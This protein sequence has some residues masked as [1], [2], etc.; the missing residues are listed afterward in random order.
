MPNMQLFKDHVQTEGVLTVPELPLFKEH[1]QIEV[2]LTVPDM[3]LF[4]DHVQPEG[5]LTVPE[6]HLFK[7]RVQTEGVLTVLDM[8]PFLGGI[9]RSG[10]T[11]RMC[12]QDPVRDRDPPS[13]SGVRMMIVIRILILMQLPDRGSRSGAGS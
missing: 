7:D 6:I 13:G 8:Q 12:I 4:K 1:V 3:Q 11:V 2:V 9:C 5:V 10:T